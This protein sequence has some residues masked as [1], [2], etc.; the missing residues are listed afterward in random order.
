MKQHEKFFVLHAIP[1]ETK[2][3]LDE[4]KIEPLSSFISPERAIDVGI[5]RLRES[6]HANEIVK[7]A[8]AYA[9]SSIGHPFDFSFNSQDDK[10]L[11]CTELVWRAYQAAGV[12]IVDSKRLISFPLL[13]SLIIPPSAISKDSNLVQVNIVSN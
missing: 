9:V 10:N 12:Q 7:L 11:Y 5:F 2:E 1:A 8:T 6:T 13:N 3:E 4:V